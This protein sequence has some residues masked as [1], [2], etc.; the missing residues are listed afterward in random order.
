MPMKADR[1][2]QPGPPH[3][4]LLAATPSEAC[5]F[6]GSLKRRPGQPPV[7]RI[8]RG[9]KAQTTPALFDEMAA[10]LQFPYYFGENWD[11]LDECLVDLEWLEGSGF[12]LIFTEA[13][14]LLAGEPASELADLLE[15]LEEAARSWASPAKHEASAA[16][17]PFHAVFQCGPDEASALVS[18]FEAIGRRLDPLK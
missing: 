12:V 4:H 6:A 10:A 11:A 9:A 3:L 8:V 2:F 5:D 17:R 13:Q 14:T 18:R 7:V 16:P 1:L 15:I